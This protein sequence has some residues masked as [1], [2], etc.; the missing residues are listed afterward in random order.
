MCLGNDSI[1][2]EN[3]VLGD[4]PLPLAVTGTGSLLARCIASACVLPSR[5]IPISQY[6]R[7]Q[8]ADGA[9]EARAAHS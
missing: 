1:T 8:K 5:G 6:A 2:R 4:A 7:L 9:E 3:L